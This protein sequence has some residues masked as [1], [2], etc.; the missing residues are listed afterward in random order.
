M[1]AWSMLGWPMRGWL[2]LLI[3]PACTP[4]PERLCEQVTR[5]VERQ[6]GPD[7]PRDPKGS[8]RAG[9]RRCIEVWAPKKKADP[10]GYACYA[11]CAMDT[12][13]I[14]ELASCRPKCFPAEARPRDEVENLDG[15]FWSSPSPSASP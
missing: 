5:V 12:K 6:F 9:V 1:L 15:L 4:S 13:E 7:D 8:H 10:K 11:S 14:V 3:L 2:L